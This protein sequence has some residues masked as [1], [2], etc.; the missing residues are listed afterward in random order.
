MSLGVSV[1]GI[2]IESA[3]GDVTGFAIVDDGVVVVVVLV[4]VVV[5]AAGAATG[6]SGVLQALPPHGSM[7]LAA[8][9]ALVTLDVDVVGAAFCAGCGAGDDRLNADDMLG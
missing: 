3:K 4:V 9:K 1:S 5:G 2:L 8:E 6:G 7:L